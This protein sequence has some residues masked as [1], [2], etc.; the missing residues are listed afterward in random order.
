MQS[1]YSS[2]ILAVE[3]HNFHSIIDAARKMEARAIIKGSVDLESTKVEHSTILK[4]TDERRF[5]HRT[6]TI[7]SSATKKEKGGKFSKKHEKNKF[8]SR[9]KSSL[10]MGSRSSS[11]SNTSSCFRCGKPHKGPC[12]FGTLEC[13]RCS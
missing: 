3:T 6:K 1:R 4:A 7:S 12:R 2:L 5:S 10:R 11:G 13:Y 8:W 9:I